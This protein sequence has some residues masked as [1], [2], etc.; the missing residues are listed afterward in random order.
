M[1][2]DGKPREINTRSHEIMYLCTDAS[3][4]P[5]EETGGIG[6][7]LCSSDGSVVSW[8]GEDLDQGFCSRLR[9]EGQTQ[10]IGELEA[11]AVLVALKR[12]SKEIGSKHLVVFVDN[13]GSKASRL[14]SS[15]WVGPLQP[16]P[17]ASARRE[18]LSSEATLVASTGNA[19]LRVTSCGGLGQGCS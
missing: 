3:Y 13:E 7:V 1:L 2:V 4:S 9:A 8:F 15:A 12:W 6:G 17:Q 11:L 18:G 5:E 16:S 14:V 10:L 19:D